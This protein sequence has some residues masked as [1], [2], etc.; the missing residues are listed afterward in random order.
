MFI[1]YKDGSIIFGGT[2]N[3]PHESITLTP[4]EMAQLTD[5]YQHKQDKAAVKEYLK[6]AISIP[7]SA[8]IS[9]EVAKKYLY[10]AGLLDQL[11][12]ESNHSQ[13]NFGDNFLTSIAKGIEALEKRLDVKEWEGLP[14][15]V[16][17]RMAHE[18]IAE[19]NPCRWTGSGDA[20]DDVGFEPLNFPIDDIYPKGDKQVLRMQLIGTTFPKLH[21]VYECSIIENGVDLWARRTQDAM[22]AGSIESLADTILYV[23]RAYELSK[24]FDSARLLTRRNMTESLPGFAMVQTSTKTASFLSMAFSRMTST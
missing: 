2:T 4:N 8:E 23:A 7:G 14:E 18:F 10:D 15:P 13:E 22:T 6:T 21:Y 12:E 5:F 20:P 9:A 3:Q 16:A 1:S 24:G 17:N 11:V 19:R